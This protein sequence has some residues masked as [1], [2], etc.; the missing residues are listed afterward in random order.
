MKLGPFEMDT[1]EIREAGKVLNSRVGLAVLLYLGYQ[2][3]WGATLNNMYLELVKLNERQYSMTS[4][5]DACIGH[6]GERT[7]NR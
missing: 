2:F 5:L 6:N 3:G 1:P 4:K 7:A